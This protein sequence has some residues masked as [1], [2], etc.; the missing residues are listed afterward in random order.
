MKSDM[1]Q[2]NQETMAATAHETKQAWLRPTMTRLEVRRTMGK[3]GS[4]TD[5][6]ALPTA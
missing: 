4:Q 2:N 6:F 5:Q 3:T 1:R